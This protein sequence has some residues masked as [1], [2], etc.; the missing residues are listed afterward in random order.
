[1]ICA[2]NNGQK[3]GERPPASGMDRKQVS[4]PRI[5][6]SGTLEDWLRTRSR[7]ARVGDLSGNRRSHASHQHGPT[8]GPR[9]HKSLVLVPMQT[10]NVRPGELHMGH[11]PN[12]Q[13]PSP[14]QPRHATQRC[15]LLLQSA[16]LPC[17][18]I[19]SVPSNQRHR[20]PHV[21]PH[22]HGA[23]CYRYHSPDGTKPEE[24]RLALP[25]L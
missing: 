23:E 22:P 7:T 15:T 13:H 16:C 17:I 1:M 14:Q 20:H 24:K 3:K 18:G 12:P 21:A 25:L 10:L 11:K 2:L 8:W 4:W 9:Q 6:R 19:S 5:L